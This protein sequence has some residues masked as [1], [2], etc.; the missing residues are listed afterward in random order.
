MSLEVKTNVTAIKAQRQLQAN[1]RKMSDSMDDE[2]ESFMW[3]KP[4]R[5]FGIYDTEG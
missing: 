3:W 5:I 2:V 1:S 4:Q